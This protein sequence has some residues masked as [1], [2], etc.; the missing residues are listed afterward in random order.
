MKTN[1]DLYLAIAELVKANHDNPRT[2]EVYLACLRRETAPYAGASRMPLDAFFSMVEAAYE[3]EPPDRLSASDGG[4]VHPPVAASYHTWHALISRQITDLCDMREAGT[5]Q[6]AFFGVSAPSGRFWHNT[7]VAG[8]LECAAEG[9]FGGWQP[10]DDTGRML[11]PGDVAYL[12]PDGS[13]GSAPASA[14]EHPVRI[15]DPL[16]WDDAIEFLRCGQSYE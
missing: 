1:R 15:I 9:A 12:K 13:I 3:V 4:H 5:L 2:L 11:V 8:F 10:G 7:S 16:T 6:Q 14:F